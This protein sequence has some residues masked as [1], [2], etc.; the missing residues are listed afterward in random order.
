MPSRLGQNFLKDH[1]ALERIAEVVEISKEDIVVEIGPGHGELTRRLLK[2]GPKKLIG[3]ELDEN[4]IKTFLVDL[5][6]E[7]ESLTIVNSDIKTYL[8]KIKE[9]DYKLV[10]NIPYYLTSHLLRIISE[11]QNKPS[12]IVLT[13][14]KEVAERICAT[15]PKMNLLAASVLYWG[16]PE[17]V[18]Y[19]SKNS[20]RP[21]PKVDSAIIK[22]IPAPRDMD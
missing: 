7:N 18:R 22:I 6:Q 16:S 4:L 1:K 11:L 2:Y 17:I 10:G 8:P 5:S 21:S 3:V 14:Q 19:I 12:L 9:K 20:F 13:V 15:P